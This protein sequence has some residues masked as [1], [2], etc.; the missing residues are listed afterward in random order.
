[1][2]GYLSQAFERN[3]HMSGNMVTGKPSTWVKPGVDFIP[4]S[5]W[6]WVSHAS[7]GGYKCGHCTAATGVSGA[8][9]AKAVSVGAKAE[10]PPFARSLRCLAAALSETKQAGT[11]FAWSAPDE[12]RR[13]R[14]P[15]VRPYPAQRP[16]CDPAHCNGP[17]MASACYGPNL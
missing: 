6:D 1:M 17:C 10:T 7:Y 15:I 9:Y 4:H 8:L 11:P 12:D 16:T 13:R 2:C 5:S 14:H 3:K